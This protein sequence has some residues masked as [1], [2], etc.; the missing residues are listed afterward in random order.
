MDKGILGKLKYNYILQLESGLR[1]GTDEKG[2]QDYQSGTEGVVD[3]EAARMSC[4][5]NLGNKQI[6]ETNAQII[7]LTFRVNF[8]LTLQRISKYQFIFGQ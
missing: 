5:L 8:G 2:K 3:I 1:F 6:K 7:L 4:L